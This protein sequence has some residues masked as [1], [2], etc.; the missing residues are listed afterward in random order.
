MR[1]EWLFWVAH[2]IM[3]AGKAFFFWFALNT[4][5][6]MRAQPRPSVGRSLPK[7]LIPIP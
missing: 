2:R 1:H 7:L 5:P 4:I 3:S 6:V